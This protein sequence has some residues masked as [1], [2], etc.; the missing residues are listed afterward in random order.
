MTPLLTGVGGSVGI[1]RWLGRTRQGGRAYR[2]AIGS[3]CIATRPTQTRM[4]SRQLDPRA[5]DRT[6]FWS[7]PACLFK[8]LGSEHSSPRTTTHSVLTRQARTNGLLGATTMRRWH[9]VRYPNC[10]LRMHAHH[11]PARSRMH[12][13]SDSCSA[14]RHHGRAPF[15]SSPVSPSITRERNRAEHADWFV[16][17][18]WCSSLP[19]SKV[20]FTA[21]TDVDDMKDLIKAKFPSA[22]RDVDAAGTRCSTPAC[23]AFLSMRAGM[24][25]CMGAALTLRA[26]NG[27]ELAEDAMVSRRVAWDKHVIGYTVPYV[28][29]APSL[30]LPKSAPASRC[31]DRLCFG[32]SRPPR[33]STSR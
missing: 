1:V 31:V 2:S 17:G 9:H 10:P 25:L 8:T 30:P 20:K 4:R 27:D 3:T 11:L 7:P 23:I 29:T 21:G 33:R 24:G 13:T 26:P 18:P 6:S 12:G 28:I 15:F 16:R 19:V 5:I 14:S 32:R 22:L